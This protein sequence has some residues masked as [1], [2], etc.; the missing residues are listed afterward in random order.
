MEI[1]AHVRRGVRGELEQ[2]EA[3]RLIP[4]F[5]RGHDGRAQ[6][7]GLFQIRRLTRDIHGEQNRTAAPGRFIIVRRR[8]AGAR[9]K[10]DEGGEGRSHRGAAEA[11]CDCDWVCGSAGSSIH[12]Q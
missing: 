8:E 9:G 2:R 5:G 1:P 3:E 4:S 11:H 12:S 10:L 7:P 6:H